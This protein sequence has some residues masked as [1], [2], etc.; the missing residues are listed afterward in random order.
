MFLTLKLYN[1][2]LLFKN[3][4]IKELGSIKIT[5][6]SKDYL[7]RKQKIKNIESIWIQVQILPD[8]FDMKYIKKLLD[9]YSLIYNI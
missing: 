5:K 1:S 4:K 7:N 3:Q 2:I 6:N 8:T 9:A